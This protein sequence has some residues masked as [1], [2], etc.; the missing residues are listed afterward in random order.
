[1]RSFVKLGLAISCGALLALSASGGGAQI[2]PP[3]K[4][5][6]YRALVHPRRPTHATKPVAHAPNTPTRA[7]PSQ[8]APTHVA[9]PAASPPPAAPVR[10][11]TATATPPP[12]VAGPAQP[13]AR[14]ALGAPMPPAELEAFVDGAVRQAMA[15]D[16]IAGVEVSVVQ[17][18][19]TVLKKGYGYAGP[20]RAV[21]PDTT[22]FRVGSISKTFTWIAL[23]KDAEAGRIRLNTPINLYL[24]EPDQVKDQ[25]FKQPI[26]VRDLMTHS[27]GF[28]DRTLGQLMETDP[29]RIRPLVLYLRQ[30]R[31]R[32][33]REPGVVPV[34]SNYGAVLAGEASAWVN[35]KPY[36]DLI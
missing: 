21:D 5:I 13:G 16:H 25:G 17:A 12:P 15:R 10:V 32:R 3:A 26:Q 31:P 19:Q 6:P 22:L 24:P 8:V 36:P 14:L 29:R 20:G 18:G 4:P 33:V 27:G 30:E 1:M 23:M 35:G 2:A 11:T 28:A 9:A 34:Y 7:L